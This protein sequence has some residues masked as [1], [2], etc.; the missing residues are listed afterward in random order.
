MAKT[1]SYGVPCYNSAEYMDVCI[2]SLLA[3]GDDIEVL[4]VDD[5]STD[6]GATL[7][8]AQAWQE[9][10]PDRVRA[11]HKGNG[12]HGSAVN[13][14]LANATGTYFKVVDSDDW[15]DPGCHG[16]SD[17][18]PALPSGGSSKRYGH[19]HRQLRL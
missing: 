7:E 19:G 14:A 9:Q 11:I 15:L 6:D 8:R 5:G 17:G 4:I 1:L 3:T 12:G 13:T 10:E 16:S 2:R 18:L